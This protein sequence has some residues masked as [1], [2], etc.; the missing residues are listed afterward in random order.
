MEILTLDSPVFYGAQNQTVILGGGRRRVFPSVPLASSKVALRSLWRLQILFTP[1]TRKHPDTSVTYYPPPVAGG[2]R[3]LLPP[4]QTMLQY[5]HAKL[6]GTLWIVPSSPHAVVMIPVAV[7]NVQLPA[8]LLL[9]T[10]YLQTR[11]VYPELRGTRRLVF[12]RSGADLPQGH[13]EL[14]NDH[15]HLLTASKGHNGVVAGK[16]SRL[17]QV[18]YWELKKKKDLLNY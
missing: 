14:M 8:D 12:S 17:R 11:A 3:E 1:M 15:L 2:K 6:S 4:A 16:G 18:G 5:L 9:W 10:V 13:V 7:G